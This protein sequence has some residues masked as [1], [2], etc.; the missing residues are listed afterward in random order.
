MSETVRIGYCSGRKIKGIPFFF[1][2]GNPQQNYEAF[3]DTHSLDRT[4]Q[5]LN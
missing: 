3:K 2:Q 1:V 5:S 4:G